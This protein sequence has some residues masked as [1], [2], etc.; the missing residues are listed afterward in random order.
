MD[1]DAPIAPDS[2]RGARK[3]NQGHPMISWDNHF[4]CRS[5]LRS[6]GQVCCRSSPCDI[7]KDWTDKM[8]RAT[9]NSALR[10]EEAGL[11]QEK[12]GQSLT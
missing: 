1:L 11:P 3:D 7:C 6:I 2:H 5:C 10:G 8:W 12:A 4:A 9:E